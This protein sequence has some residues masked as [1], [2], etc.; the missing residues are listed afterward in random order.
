MADEADDLEQAHRSRGMWSG[1][2][3]FGLVSVPVS[4]YPA[5]RNVGVR[6]RMLSPTGTPLARRYECPAEGIEVHPEH[7]IR[8]YEVEP[9]RF[10]TVTGEELESLEPEKSRDIDLQQFVNLEELD[11]VYF[12]RAYFL[13]PDSN[14][15]KAYR[16][17]AG[18]MEKSKKAGIARFVMR[19]KEYLIA[20]ISENGILRAET[21][22]FFDEVRTPEEID[23]PE[24]RPVKATDRATFESA[25]AKL[26]KKSLDPAELQ[27]MQMERL[28]A[29]ID[30]KRRKKEDVVEVD[31]AIDD[32]ES[33]TEGDES[34]DLIEVLRASLAGRANGSP[35]RRRAG[36]EDSAPVRKQPAGTRGRR[37]KP[38]RETGSTRR[39]Q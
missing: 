39:R 32:E 2:I 12:E 18:A 9:G 29:L 3:S 33:D 30:R 5:V 6:L 10:I 20:I 35:G 15:T 31:A 38:A 21:M 14:S 22:R 16:L 26:S 24:P 8:G 7:L 27:N 37:R 4:L 13:V 1:T 34:V 17:L 23:L 19:E 36:R 11:P 25:I 28:L